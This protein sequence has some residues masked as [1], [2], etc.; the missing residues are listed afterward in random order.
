[1]I[2]ELGHFALILAFL[3]ALMQ[4]AVPLVGAARG[5]AGV[6]GGWAAARPC[7][8]S[9]L[10]ATS[11]VALTLLFV[12]SDFSRPPG[13]RQFALAEAAALQD[14]R[15]VGQPRG[16][17][18][19]VG[20]ILPLFGAAVAGFGATLPTRLRARVLGGAGMIGV[21]FLLFILF[22]SNPFLRLG[23]GAAARATT[24]TRCCRIPAS[25]FIRRFSI[26]A[27][28]ASRSRSPSRS[29]R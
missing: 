21:G 29:R 18:A 1:M 24:S 4:A 20:A 3:A 27:M 19:A 28:S 25:P 13:R 14:H 10:V 5:E 2:A 8:S 12:T 17:D 23:A 9:G 26:S 16:L 15:R 22:T 11:F 7:C 6:D